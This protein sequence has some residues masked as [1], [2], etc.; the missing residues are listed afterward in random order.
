MNACGRYAIGWAERPTLLH[1]IGWL[2]HLAN[3]TH[4]QYYKNNTG[5]PTL[6]VGQYFQK[7]QEGPLSG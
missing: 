5:G 2:D 4:Q 1:K 7:T 6:R 3:A